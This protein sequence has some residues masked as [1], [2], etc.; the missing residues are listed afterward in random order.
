MR[1][2]VFELLF[3]VTAV[4]FNLLIAALF[5]ATKKTY[6]KWMRALGVAWLSLALPLVIVFVHYLLDNR[7]T[8]VMLAFG[9]VFLYMIVEGLL[10]Y[11]IKFDFRSRWRWHIPYIVLEYIALFCLIGIAF[12]VDRVAGYV[13]SISFWILM[14]SLIY[15]YASR[16]RQA[17]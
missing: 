5:I 8:A 16:K 1:W 17:A 3:V 4:A 15:L 6:R 9:G 2:D 13:V 11:V 10:D 7:A 12:S 14:A